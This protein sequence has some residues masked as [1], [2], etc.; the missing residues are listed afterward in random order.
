[1]IINSLAARRSSQDGLEVHRPR[2]AGG[3]QKVPI[4]ESHFAI[5]SI[6]SFETFEIILLL[7]V[8]FEGR[9][10]GSF[11]FAPMSAVQQPVDLLGLLTPA[12][13]NPRPQQRRPPPLCPLAQN[14]F[15][16]S[17]L[18]VTAVEQMRQF[19]HCCCR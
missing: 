1:M 6:Q 11:R 12:A 14:V 15:H 17:E 8:V 18:N 4:L 10:P 13:P 9:R 19:N 3:R 16:S 7:Q 2:P 5:N